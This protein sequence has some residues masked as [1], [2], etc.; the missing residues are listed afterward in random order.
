MEYFNKYALKLTL[1]VTL[2]MAPLYVWGSAVMAPP[3]SGSYTASNQ[4]TLSLLYQVE[5]FGSG[6]GEVLLGVPLAQD[7]GYFHYLGDDA[8]T[9]ANTSNDA[10]GNLGLVYPVNGADKRTITVF[11]ELFNMDYNLAAASGSLSDSRSFTPWLQVEQQLPMLMPRARTLTAGETNDAG[12]AARLHDLT[13]QSFASGLFDLGDGPEDMGRLFLQ[14]CRL[15]GIPARTVYGYR[16]TS[17]EI[18]RYNVPTVVPGTLSSWVEAYIQGIGWIPADFSSPGATFGKLDIYLLPLSIETQGLGFSMFSGSGTVMLSR[19][20]V[21]TEVSQ[22]PVPLPVA[23][24]TFDERDGYALTGAL[25][26][27]G[28]YSYDLRGYALNDAQW[29]SHHTSLE[30]GETPV[31]YRVQNSQ[32]QWSRWAVRLLKVID[33]NS[34]PVAQIHLNASP[35]FT[36]STNFS[37]IT[38]SGH[39][40]AGLSVVEMEWANRRDNY[41]DGRHL[42]RLRVQD[43]RGVWSDWAGE[44]LLIGDGI[45]RPVA[46]I[47]YTPRGEVT[48]A[49]QFNWTYENSFDPD[50]EAIISHQW[51]NERTNYPVGVHTVRL[52]VQNARGKWSEWAAVTLN[53]TSNQPARAPVAVIGIEPNRR[54]FVA[55]EEVEVYS[56]S[57][58]LDGDLLIQEEWQGRMAAYNVPGTY[59]IR[60][61][62]QNLRGVWSPWEMVTFVVHPPSSVINP[63]G[64]VTSPGAVPPTWPTEPAPPPVEEVTVAPTEPP[65]TPAKGSP[66]YREDGTPNRAPIAR[67][68][69]YP[70]MIITP[71]TQVALVGTSYDPDWDAITGEEWQNLRT[72]YTLGEHIV[73]YR[74]KDSYGLWGEWDTITLFSVNSRPPLAT[75]TMVPLSPKAGETVRFYGSATSPEGTLITAEEWENRQNSYGGGNHVVRYRAQD[76][77]GLWSEWVEVRF[78]IRGSWWPW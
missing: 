54:E 17:A 50:G 44:E 67:I 24:I 26:L 39:S 56:L 14:L 45:Q 1:I 22:N 57:Y 25:N 2:L 77:N 49:S 3:S 15:F 13:K 33:R 72:S 48:T 36:E 27:S 32:G 60:L 68:N 55:P 31:R 78:S 75:L 10:L 74:V 34:I 5:R 62:V 61:R 65:T 43:T 16:I 66:N 20:L 70:G 21:R 37:Y 28:D 53:V 23:I 42:L 8:P 59:S 69:V 58:D 18:A 51:E 71:S 35:P 41:P 63:D 6:L 12:R 7:M 29:D 19:S 73:R 30:V 52:R 40:P 47:S 9:D 46:V 4:V 11:T 64:S 38:G 76:A